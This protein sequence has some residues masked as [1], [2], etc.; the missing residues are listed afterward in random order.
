M[1][2]LLSIT[3]NMKP[4]SPSSP[5]GRDSRSWNWFLSSRPRFGY[6]CHS[7]TLS[8]PPYLV[9]NFSLYLFFSYQKPILQVLQI[10]LRSP[11]SRFPVIEKL[12]VDHNLILRHWK[13]K[14]ILLLFY[15]RLNKRCGSPL[16]ARIR[17]EGK[18]KFRGFP[19]L[20]YAE[21]KPPVKIFFS[22]LNSF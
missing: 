21:L 15:L 19:L 4:L 11:F 6:P 17:I 18:V 1:R 3:F 8:I 22:W 5:P 12:L 13:Q 7:S 10:L 20:P 9:Q 14:K 16:K 2:L